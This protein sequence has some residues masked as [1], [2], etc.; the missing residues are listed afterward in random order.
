MNRFW[1]GQWAP[2]EIDPIKLQ[3]FFP[4][5]QFFSHCTDETL[6]WAEL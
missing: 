5:L 6:F 4:H 3:I 1:N 2:R